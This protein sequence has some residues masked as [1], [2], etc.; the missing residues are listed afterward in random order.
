MMDTQDNNLSFSSA[1]GDH[2]Q[3]PSNFPTPSV[4]DVV[5]KEQGIQ[6]CRDEGSGQC[7]PLYRLFNY[8]NSRRGSTIT[9][10]QGACDMWD[11]ILDIHER[12]IEGRD[13]I[14]DGGSRRFAELDN[15][16]NTVV[17]RKLLQ[18]RLVWKLQ[19]ERSVL[20][21]AGRA[22]ATSPIH[23]RASPS[24]LQSVSSSRMSV[25]TKGASPCAFHTKR[26][27]DHSPIRS[28]QNGASSSCRSDDMFIEVS[29]PRSST[30]PTLNYGDGYQTTQNHTNNYPEM[31][32]V[33]CSKRRKLFSTSRTTDCQAS[34]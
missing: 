17:H 22:L 13:D 2:Q 20:V 12:S 23:K 11:E 28:C 3:Q 34:S 15:G 4:E 14:D 31:S 30:P 9:G 27:P 1:A 5:E 16:E 25:I 29:N 7:R 32:P 33:R 10:N 24:P 26:R 21:A 18:R 8:A 6:D 19:K